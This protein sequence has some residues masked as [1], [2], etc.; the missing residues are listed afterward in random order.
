[1]LD[2]LRTILRVATLPFPHFTEHIVMRDKRLMNRVPNAVDA[3][4]GTRSGRP[5][6]HQPIAC[7]TA[8]GYTCASWAPA[9]KWRLYLPIP[10][11]QRE[12]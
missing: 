7:P 1:M 2:R 8:I 11:A 12:R 4:P 9:C 3:L 6:L 10:P 5:V